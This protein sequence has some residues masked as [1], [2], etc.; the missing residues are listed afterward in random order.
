MGF[1]PNSGPHLFGNVVPP[2]AS[3]PRPQ[4][5]RP[6]PPLR[7]E[8]PGAERKEVRSPNTEPSFSSLPSPLV[9]LPAPPLVQAL[10]CW[11][12]AGAR[13]G[14][15]NRIS[16]TVTLKPPNPIDKLGELSPV[17][18]AGEGGDQE[19]LRALVAGQGHCLSSLLLPWAPRK[20]E[21]R[22]RSADSPS[23]L[24]PHPCGSPLQLSSALPFWD[25]C[26]CLLI[27]ARGRSR[28]PRL[29]L[30]DPIPPRPRCLREEGPSGMATHPASVRSRAA[31][32]PQRWAAS[33]QLLLGAAPVT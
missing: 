12:S 27:L 8:V 29:V 16:S 25:C 33:L 1:F 14:R 30:G 6:C 26:V 19:A 13:E 9:F 5:L 20:Q 15:I 23:T 4:L 32:R 17:G 22:P 2:H 7:A 11:P 24:T 3:S 28:A 31:Q 21:G 10:R 18:Q